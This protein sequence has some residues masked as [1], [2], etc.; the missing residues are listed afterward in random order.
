LNTRNH[1]KWLVCGVLLA[2]VLIPKDVHAQ[3]DSSW[4]AHSHAA[5]DALAAGDT[6]GYRRHLRALRDQV[7]TTP[8]LAARLAAAAFS[9]GD[10]AD[11]IRWGRALAAMGL[12]FD[13]GLVARF[14]IPGA[15][16]VLDSMLSSN[17]AGMRTIDESRFVS[18]LADPD[19]IAED[20][21]YDAPRRRFLVSSVRRG[22][23]YALSRSGRVSVLVPSGMKDVWGILALGIDTRRGALWATTAAFPGTAGY[24]PGDS[25]QSA[26][27]EY[28][29]ATGRR[30]ARLVTTDPG[31]HAFGDLTVGPDGTVYVS[32]GFGGGVYAIDPGA[33]SLRPLVPPGTFSSPQ[34]PALSGDGRRL[35]V[36]DYTFGIAVIDLQ[37]GRWH[38]VPHPDSLALSGIDGLYATGRDLIAVQNGWSPNRIACLRLDAADAILDWRPLLRGGEGV[39]LNHAVRVGDSLYFI[40]RSGWDRVSDDGKMKAGGPGDAPVIRRFAVRSGPAGCPE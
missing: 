29:L 13:T 36:P 17:R 30:R 24:T 25:G 11:G 18:R 19:M 37:H 21:V 28:D 16:G 9:V 14:L 34:T 8:R 20:I 22:A 2:A 5:G 26:I 4:R 27:L 6:A 10:T 7:G 39:D 38:W 31:P 33:R 15:P 3:Y 40:A 1:P 32:D 35:F 23:I 12:P